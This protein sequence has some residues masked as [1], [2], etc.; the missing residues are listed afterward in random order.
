VKVSGQILELGGEAMIQYL[1]PLLHIQLIMLGEKP[2]WFL[3]KKGAIAR[4]S[5]ITDPL[6]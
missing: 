3:L 1:A 5:Q 6:V 4:W 2:W